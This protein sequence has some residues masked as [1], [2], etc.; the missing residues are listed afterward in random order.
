MTEEKFT[1]LVN[2]HLDSEIPEDELKLLKSELAK[3]AS[4]RE[5]YEERVRLEKAM[6]MA[7]GCPLEENLDHSGVLPA[8]RGHSKTILHFPRWVIGFGVAASFLLAAVFLPQALQQSSTTSD[9]LA[10]SSQDPLDSFSLSEY[11]PFA[12]AQAETLH[13]HV[14]LASHMRLLGLRPE[15]TPQDK[16]LQV[17]QFS[18]YQPDTNGKSRAE[19]LQELQKLRVFPEIPVLYEDRSS[20]SSGA[21]FGNGFSASL[22]RY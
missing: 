14:S 12:S 9:E 3:N 21:S 17:V 4:R 10:V 1:E 8:P 7:F 16:E 13:S 19:L 22:V 15:H 5:L 18:D 6:R 11:E 2:L 20:H